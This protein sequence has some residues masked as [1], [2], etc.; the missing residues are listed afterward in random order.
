MTN[1]SKRCSI[2]HCTFQW[3]LCEKRTFVLYQPARLKAWH[4]PWSWWLINFDAC[5]MAAME[6]QK[7]N[8][9]DLQKI[10][11]EICFYHNLISIFLTCSEVDI[12]TE[13]TIE[14][15]IVRKCT[16]SEKK[17]SF[18]NYRKGRQPSTTLH[19]GVSWQ[20]V[21]RGHAIQ[22]Y[23]LLRA[24]ALKT[25]INTCIFFLNIGPETELTTSVLPNARLR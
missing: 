10:Y 20:L 17:C 22:Y 9:K 23:V 7:V 13:W 15:T 8:V 12:A 1:S 25:C 6:P 18:A 24:A 5:S 21:H 11:C 4:K 16:W 14:W 19:E 2:I 3:S